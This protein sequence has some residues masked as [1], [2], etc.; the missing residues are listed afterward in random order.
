MRLRTARYEI[1]TPV[2]IPTFFR[3]SMNRDERVKKRNLKVYMAK[4]AGRVHAAVVEDGGKPRDYLVSDASFNRMWRLV[5]RYGIHLGLHPIY[6]SP[7]G[8]K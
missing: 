1:A 8:D 3:R 4:M 5:A 6:Y 7:K 2:P